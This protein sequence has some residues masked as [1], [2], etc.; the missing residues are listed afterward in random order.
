MR[1]RKLK[2]WTEEQPYNGITEKRNYFV[3]K[4]KN[5]LYELNIFR[6]QQPNREREKVKDGKIIMIDI[7]R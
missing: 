1:E 5:R 4:K 6:K 2:K 3:I 7:F